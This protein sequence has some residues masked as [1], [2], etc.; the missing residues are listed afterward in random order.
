MTKRDCIMKYDPEEVLRQEFIPTV[1]V[2]LKSES[3]P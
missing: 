3:K 2:H 1:S